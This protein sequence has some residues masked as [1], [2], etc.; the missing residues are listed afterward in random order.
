[1]YSMYNDADLMADFEEVVSVR[2]SSV[3][4]DTSKYFVTKTYDNNYKTSQHI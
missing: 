3:Y 2:G 4:T 1:M